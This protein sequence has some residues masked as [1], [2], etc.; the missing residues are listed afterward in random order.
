VILTCNEYMLFYSISC[1]Q[2]L[3]YSCAARDWIKYSSML[4]L[5]CTLLAPHGISRGLLRLKILGVDY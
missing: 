5:V 1:C 4:S 2:P 3:V